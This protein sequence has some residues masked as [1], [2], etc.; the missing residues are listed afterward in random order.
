MSWYPLHPGTVGLP[1]GVMCELQVAGAMAAILE[2]LLMRDYP[3]PHGRMDEMLSDEGAIRDSWRDVATALD[4]LGVDALRQR[5]QQARRLL[6]ERGVTYNVYGDPQGSERPWELDPVPLVLSSDEWAEV[7]SGLH[8]RAELF[9]LIL[10]D[11]YGPQ[12]LIRRGLLPQELIHAHPGFLR[13][14]HP[15]DQRLDYP[16]CLYAADLARG[17]DGRFRVV[18]DRTQSPSGAG[19]ALENRVVMSR[20]LPSL[21]RESRVHRLALFFHHLRRALAEL[22]PNR[23]EDEP[24][25]VLLTPGLMNE[26]YFEHS[27]LAGYLGYTLVEGS[28]LTVRDGRVWLRSMR[29]LEPVDVIL[30]RLD[31]DY[32]DGVELRRDSML[33][34]PGLTEVVRR[35]RV[36]VAN[37][38][39]AGVLENPALKVFLPAIAR[40]FLGH[41]LDL[42]SVPTWWCGDPE[43]REHVL[44]NLDTLVVKSIYRGGGQAPVFVSALTS[45]QRTA[46]A[47]RIRARPH[48]YVGQEHGRLSSVPTLT[49]A[50]LQ[51]RAAVIRAFMVAG[52]GGYSIM[53]GGL[54]RVAPASDS[55]SVSNQVGGQ[56]KDIWIRATEPVRTVSLL[57]STDEV[58]MGAESRAILPPAA[59]ANLFWMSR[60]A[61]RAEQAA[62]ALRTV[63]R[64][65]RSVTEFGD[66]IDQQVLARLQVALTRVTA[67]YPGV[68]SRA[69]SP[70]DPLQELQ[71]LAF[72]S[73]RTGTVAFNLTAMLSASNGVR[74]RLTSDALR[75]LTSLRLRLGGTGA[76]DDPV[77]RELPAALDEMVT[78]LAALRGL[79]QDSMMHGQ[80]WRFMEMGRHIERG[81]LTA[82]WLRATLVTPLAA[83]DEPALLEALLTTLES[84][85]AYR[86]RYHD[87]PRA[88]ALL[89]LVLL[90][91]NNPRA[92]GYQ[93]GSLREALQELP[94][95]G[96]PEEL[97]REQ[98]LVLE[99]YTS[100][101]LSDPAELVHVPEGRADRAALERLLALTVRD[102]RATADCLAATYFSDQQ[103]PRPLGGVPPAVEYPRS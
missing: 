59:A 103:G 24:R 87:T 85:G 28:D 29:R 93:L 82:E 11:I 60:Y 33:G 75:V 47:R 7:E 10:K 31:D 57:P 50:G 46:L 1:V 9:N 12:D 44:A 86:R 101:R 37:P 96:G 39:G 26:T 76:G 84:L 41:D 69:D 58:A 4:E 67:T 73:R 32:C 66:G 2:S 18:G 97:S 65:Y 89:R 72:D 5:H 16:L 30:R 61:E 91:E 79:E 36:A 100:L 21:F 83:R 77:F 17:P 68:A 102:L 53:P 78:L 71:S 38:L 92:L 45:D 90:S 64:L 62:R 55:L 49:D 94:S 54:A 56:S 14:C 19:Y 27:L 88:E 8:R 43:S 74:D 35:G 51:P 6:R 63:L 80:A 81:L 52:K 40:H 13:P 23:D 25:V 34:V 99:A 48:L 15:Y 22:A 3:R 95:E 20:I 98:R 42:P 70:V